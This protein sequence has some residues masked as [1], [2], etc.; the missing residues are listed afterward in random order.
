MYNTNSVLLY[1]AQDKSVHIYMTCVLVQCAISRQLFYF[2]LNLVQTFAVPNLNE[3]T[4]IADKS[5][6]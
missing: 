3:F 1:T 5:K 2:P 6:L 4:F